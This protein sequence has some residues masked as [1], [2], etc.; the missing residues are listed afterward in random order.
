V[1]LCNLMSRGIPRRESEKLVV[2]GFFGE[3]T[4][5]IPLKGLK[6]KLDRAIEGKIGLG[7]EERVA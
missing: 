3:V 4:S 2:F 5:R 7:F 1:E 6:D